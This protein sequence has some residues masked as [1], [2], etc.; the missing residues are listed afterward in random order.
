M[1]FALVVEDG[2]IVAGANSYVSV[3]D[4][5]AI[6][7]LDLQTDPA[8]WNAL[9]T[10]GKSKWLAFATRW[11]DDR[12]VW[13]GTRVTDP[14]YPRQTP[15]RTPQPL[16]WPRKNAHDRERR[17]ISE[18]IVPSEVKRATALIAN[19]YLNGDD[20]E[21][22]AGIRRFRAD[23]FEIEYQQGWFKSPVPPWLKYALFG[24]GQIGGETGFKKIVRV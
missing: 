20:D 1:P 18:I 8:K 7:A 6:I 23:T 5:D 10:E 12:M 9:D 17:A 21:L 2:T 4:A 16:G 22:Q 14:V 19:H 15:T 3:A 24:L 11:L 13:N